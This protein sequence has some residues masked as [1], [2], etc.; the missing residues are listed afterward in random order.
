MISFVIP[1][2]MLVWSSLLPYVKA[3]T[4]SMSTLRIM[5][6]NSY[7]EILPILPSLL[8]NTLTLMLAVPTLAVLIST[9]W[10]VTR[11]Q[12]PGRKCIEFALMAALAVPS[13]VG[14][15]AFLYLGLSI[16][17]LV[18]IYTTIWIMV[19]AIAARELTWGNR[20]IS[21]SMLQLHKELEEACAVSGVSKGRTFVS[22]VLPIVSPALL[23]SWFWLALLTARNL[24]TP[25]MLVRPNTEVL[26][27]AIWGFNAAGKASVA[28]A[29]G[30]VLLILMAIMIIVFQI[31]IRKR[32]G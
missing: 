11:T 31:F 1:L 24:T 5:N 15:L 21:A 9:A 7:R 28:S 14:A 17:R 3:P 22:V 13:I 2:I 25:I 19:V 4:L 6:L 16:Y 12:F 20:T 26:A 32:N 30:V 27:T 10:V 29:L 18:P 23:Y 8:R